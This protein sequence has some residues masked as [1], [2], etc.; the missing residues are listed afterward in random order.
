[1]FNYWI[2]K[3]QLEIVAN[4]MLIFGSHIKHHLDKKNI[5][6]LHDKSLLDFIIKRFFINNPIYFSGN[7]SVSFEHIYMN[8]PA[9]LILYYDHIGNKFTFVVKKCMLTYVVNSGNI[10]DYGFLKD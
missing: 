2:R 8:N 1:M 10:S 5:A 9:D 3:R 6:A 4:M 7:G